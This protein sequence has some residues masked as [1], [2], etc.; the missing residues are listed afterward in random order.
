MSLIPTQT[1]TQA[2]LNAAFQACSAGGDQYTPSDQTFLI[3]KN[4]DVSAHTVT[5]V[6]TATAFGQ[7]I[8]NISVIVPAGGMMLM[9]PYEPGEVIQPGT[10]LADLTYSGVTGMSIAAVST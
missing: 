3:V 5:L 1:M 6:T 7:P 10:N 8:S 9:G 4:S 2:G